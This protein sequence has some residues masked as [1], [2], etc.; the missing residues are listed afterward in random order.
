MWEGGLGYCVT[1]VQVMTIFDPNPIEMVS[2][3]Q[4]YQPVVQVNLVSCVTQ[5]E[6][7]FLLVWT[8][9]HSAFIRWMLIIS[10]GKWVLWSIASQFACK[11]KIPKLKVILP[12]LTY[13][14]QNFI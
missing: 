6:S 10:K 3:A 13:N 11:F 5:D 14:L 9:Q 4:L 2:A 8:M 7:N 12:Y 1:A